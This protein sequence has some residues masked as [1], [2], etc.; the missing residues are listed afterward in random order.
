MRIAFDGGSFQQGI[1]GGIHSV[2]VNFLNACRRLD[3]DFDVILVLDPR[4]GPVNPLAMAQ[5]NWTPDTVS[6]PVGPAYGADAEG[7]LGSHNPAVRFFV[8]GKLFTPHATTGSVTYRGPRPEREFVILSR[9]TRPV[10]VDGTPDNRKLG[11]AITGMILSDGTKTRSIDYDDRRLHRGFDVVESSFRWTD[12]CAFVPVALFE[13]MGEEISL[14]LTYN[15]FNT[16]PLSPG[17][18]LDGMKTLRREVEASR[19]SIVTDDLS[20]QLRDAGCEF[21]FA[22]HFIPAHMPY[23]KRVAWA[24]DLIPVLFPQFF[25]PDARRNF[26]ANIDVFRA[27]DR[28]YTIS[29]STLDDLA[30][31]LNLDRDHLRYAGI[32]ADVNIS[33]REPAAVQKVLKT[34]G[35]KKSE[36]IIMVSTV[37]PR[38]NHLRLLEAYQALRKRVPNCPKLVMVGQMGWDFQEVLNYRDSHG[39]T[40]EAMILSNLSVDD[41]SCLY[42]GALFSVYPSVYEGFGLP[43]VESM[44][45]GT[46]VLT[47]NVSSMA[48]IAADAALTVDPYDVAAIAQGLFKMTTDAG[49]R[50]NLRIKGDK[51]CQD[52]TWD[53]TAQLILDDLESLAN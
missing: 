43:V 28:V 15:A 6:A 10:D 38:K 39:L 52:Y 32:A 29:H 3:P 23:Q 7:P 31:T 50:T 11:I 17:R 36:Y 45:C 13:D 34:F 22:N 51:R 4:L 8:D 41:L 30:E 47:S 1:L 24:Y 5:L 49:L 46:P 37:E 48:E 18:L 27:A 33:K 20:A 40:N 16:Y 19:R 53:R 21:Y 35:L 25:H 14:H 2:A 42:T 26:D 12:G 9:S 44:A